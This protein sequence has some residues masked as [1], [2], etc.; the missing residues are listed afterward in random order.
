MPSNRRW[1]LSKAAVW[2]KCKNKLVEYADEDTSDTHDEFEESELPDQF[3][4]AEEDINDGTKL[5]H[6]A[7]PRMCVP[8]EMCWSMPWNWYLF[9]EL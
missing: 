5:H 9:Q 7:T 8:S 1:W 2:N 4:E 3:G 6:H